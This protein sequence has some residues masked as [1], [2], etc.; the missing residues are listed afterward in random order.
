MSGNLLVFPACSQLIHAS[1]SLHDSRDDFRCSLEYELLE[2]KKISGELSESHRQVAEWQFCPQFRTGFPQIQTRSAT[3]RRNSINSVYNGPALKVSWH[4]VKSQHFFLIF[5][6][7]KLLLDVCS[8]NEM[9]FRRCFSLHLHSS[10]N[11]K[12]FPMCGMHQTSEK[13]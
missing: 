1:R 13:N 3:S 5:C 12:W 9:L 8:D 4:V 7:H 11:L 2:K 10:F 6:F